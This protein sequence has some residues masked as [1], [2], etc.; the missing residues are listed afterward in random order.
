MG[1]DYGDGNP[2]SKINYYACVKKGKSKQIKIVIII[3]FTD[4]IKNISRK[5]W[6][7]S[8]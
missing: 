1:S 2:E 4:D 6:V 3:W 5:Y 8:W 7:W